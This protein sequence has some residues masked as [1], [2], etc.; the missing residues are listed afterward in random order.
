ML[1]ANTTRIGCGSVRYHYIGMIRMILVCN[2]GPSGN[3]F[4]EQ[5]YEPGYP[6]PPPI[7]PL[8]IPVPSSATRTTFNRLFFSIIVFCSV[9]IYIYT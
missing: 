7:S 5:M 9:M 2:Y 8:Q 1:W 3:K 4:G 6:K